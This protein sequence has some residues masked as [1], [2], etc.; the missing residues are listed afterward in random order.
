MPVLAVPVIPAYFAS[1]PLGVEANAVAREQQV[2][3]P[4]LLLQVQAMLQQLQQAN[5]DQM[6]NPEQL[7]LRAD[8][9]HLLA[10]PMSQVQVLHDKVR[11]LRAQL[12]QL[13]GEAADTMVQV[14]TGRAEIRLKHKSYL[15]SMTLNSNIVHQLQLPQLTAEHPKAALTLKS[16]TGEGL[17]V[18]ERHWKPQGNMRPPT[19]MVQ[20]CW[21]QFLKDEGARAGGCACWCV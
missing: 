11:D 17:V 18:Y 7:Q 21:T 10:Q 3:L 15:R 8:L 4:E 14:V 5:P 19:L 20:F 12:Q 1:P 16:H 6:Q 9:E 13:L 2:L